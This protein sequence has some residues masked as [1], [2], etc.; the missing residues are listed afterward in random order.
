MQR[1]FHRRSIIHER[2]QPCISARM[3]G[4]PPDDTVG[5]GGGDDLLDKRHAV[6]NVADPG[7]V[8]LEIVFV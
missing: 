5:N 4:E 2:L 6:N 3:V 7:D 1:R 8:L